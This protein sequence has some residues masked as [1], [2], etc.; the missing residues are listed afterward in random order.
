V[1]VLLLFATVTFD[2]FKE[3]PAWA[4]LEAALMGHGPPGVL[5]VTLGLLTFPLLF[6]VLFLVTC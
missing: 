3:T 5:L 4:S 6:L 1:F 2:G